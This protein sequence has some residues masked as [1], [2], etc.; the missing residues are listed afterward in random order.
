LQRI[1]HTEVKQSSAEPIAQ[2][3]GEVGPWLGW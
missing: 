3:V 2:A 1:G